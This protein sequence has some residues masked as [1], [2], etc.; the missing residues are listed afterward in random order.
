M[1]RYFKIANGMAAGQVADRVAG[2]K[3]NDSGLA[4]HLAQLAQGVLL[5]GRKPVLKKVDVVGH[6]VPASASCKIRSQV[7]D[8]VALTARLGRGCKPVP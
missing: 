8:A 3:Q 1:D 4:G 7:S 2:E 5:I 6:S